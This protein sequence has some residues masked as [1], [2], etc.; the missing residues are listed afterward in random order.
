MKVH[1]LNCGTMRPFGGRLLDGSGP[2][3]G[4][5]TMV[6]HCLLLETDDGLV[7]VDS[8]L[9][10]ADVRHPGR[11]LA[12]PW[13]LLCRPVL[14]E[15]E[16]AVRQVEALGHRAQ[17][18]RHVVLTHLDLDHGGG[19]RDFPHAEVH[20]LAEEL[21]DALRPGKSANERIRYPDRQWAHGP[22]WVTHEPTGERWFG[23]AG[24]R[25]FRPDVLLVP[26]IGHT[27][28]HTGVAVDTGDGWLLHAGD[29]YFHHGEMAAP[30][31]CPPGLKFLQGRMDTVR[32]LRLSNQDR[33]RELV[34]DHGD[35]VDVF[36]AHDAAELRR[37]RIRAAG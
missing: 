17:D 20:V 26:L 11:T 19:L 6:C 10:L 9:G 12:K 2:L 31:H 21:A 4:A 3:L 16:T 5:A 27:R 14:D 37:H 28:G 32:E 13:R 1:H 22:K 18:V 23:F 29:S 34:R 30:P 33:L 36:S 24:V 15:A 8:G 35:R 25:E 7:L